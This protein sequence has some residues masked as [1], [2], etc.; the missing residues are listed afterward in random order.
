MIRSLDLSTTV[1]NLAYLAVIWAMA[2]LM[3]WRYLH[4]SPAQRRVSRWLLYA[5]L[6][7]GAGDLFHLVARALRTFTGVEGIAGVWGE[8]EIS[9]VGLGLFAT[10][11]T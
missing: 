6:M 10:S 1:F 9:W 8:Q 7:L 2:A 4:H 5:V 11:F 3:G